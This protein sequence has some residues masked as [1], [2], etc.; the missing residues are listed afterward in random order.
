MEGKEKGGNSNERDSQQE[1]K[2]ERLK[3][4]SSSNWPAVNYSHV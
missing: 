1:G 2:E 4:K 3:M